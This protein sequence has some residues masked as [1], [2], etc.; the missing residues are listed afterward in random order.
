M[1]NSDE[2]RSGRHVVFI[3]HAH[4]VFTP[5]Y[6]KKIF[7]SAHL[8]ALENYVRKVCEDMEVELVEFNGE[9]D[10]VH[11][12]VNYPPKLALSN[13]VNSLK[14]VTSRLLRKDFPEI[15]RYYWKNKTLWSRSYFVSSCG[16][17]PLEILKQY[18]QDQDRPE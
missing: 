16:G 9:P 12:L 15:E 10:H 18:I 13:L 7:E 2:Y 8:L 17:A 3:L 14:G 1:K 6:R 5:K 11:L 4:L